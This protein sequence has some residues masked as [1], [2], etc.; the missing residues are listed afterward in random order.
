MAH[1]PTIEKHIE[2]IFKYVETKGVS[3]FPEKGYLAGEL[4]KIVE[5][6]EKDSLET[7]TMS[8]ILTARFATAAV[9]MWLRSV[10]SFL[11]SSSLTNVSPLWSS[12]TGYYSSHYCVR[13]LAHLLGY[14]QLHRKKR[15]VNVVIDGGKQYCT[16]VKKGGGDGEHKCYWRIVKGHSLF[17]GNPFF[18]L[19]E[20]DKKESDAG[21][22]NL[23]NYSDHLN[24]FTTFRPL[25]EEVLKLRIRHL[26]KIELSA[27]P[28]P[29]RD[30]YPDVESV[31]LIAYHRIV[32]F[33]KLIDDIL[34]GNSNFWSIHR[35]PSW[36]SS[37]LDFQVV[38]PTFTELYKKE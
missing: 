27:V 31:Q 18:I 28:I 36:C 19:N 6:A 4:S 25:D 29:N 15:I 3:A 10:H 38:P 1:A 8:P 21:H 11:I 17:S 23:A 5:K 9:E 32:F 30:R 24:R 26:S 16:I 2:I 37:Y 12:V 13:G 14:F 33:R 7:V 20:E 22:R 34:G 35:T